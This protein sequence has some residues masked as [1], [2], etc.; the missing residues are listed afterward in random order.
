MSAMPTLQRLQIRFGRRKTSRPATPRME[1]KLCHTIIVRRA[2]Q[3]REDGMPRGE[4][5]ISASLPKVPEHNQADHQWYTYAIHP[6][7]FFCIGS[8]SRTVS[9]QAGATRSLSPPG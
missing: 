9:S 4:P 3:K 2:W 5:L 8:N 6:R 7:P 1:M